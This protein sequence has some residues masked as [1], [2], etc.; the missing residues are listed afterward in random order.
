MIVFVLLSL[1][2]VSGLMVAHA[3]NLVHSI[4][5]PILVFHD[6]LGLLLLSGLN[7]S[8]MIFLVVH[9]GAIVVSF[10]FIVMMFHIQIAEIHEEVLHYLPVSG[11]I[12]PIL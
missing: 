5:L 11:I 10:L 8:A 12:G 2:L 1:A 9:I 6:T 3:K 4:L 7:F